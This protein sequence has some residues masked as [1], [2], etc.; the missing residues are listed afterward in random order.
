MNLQPLNTVCFT[1][2]LVCIVLGAVLAISMIWMDYSSEF[3]WKSWS[4]IGVLFCATSLTLVVSKT[5]GS[6]KHAAS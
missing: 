5:F 1:V 6:R 2:S 4:T 3:L